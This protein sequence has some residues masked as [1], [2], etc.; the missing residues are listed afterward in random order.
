M[1]QDFFPEILGETIK[2]LQDTQNTSGGD[3]FGGSSLGNMAVSLM[4]DYQ[5]PV[6]R[7]AMFI[8]TMG[9]K[10]FEAR[11]DTFAVLVEVVEL[12]EKD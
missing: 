6:E 3:V 1:A 7:L 11:A 8:L 12:S 10:A 9:V 4:E 5:I 2:L